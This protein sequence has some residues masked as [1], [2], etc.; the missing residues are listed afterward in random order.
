MLRLT[1]GHAVCAVKSADQPQCY[2]TVLCSR[3]AASDHGEMLLGQRV[4]KEDLQAIKQGSCHP[5]LF[6]T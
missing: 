4:L 6:E 3:D 2:P 5:T 1:H